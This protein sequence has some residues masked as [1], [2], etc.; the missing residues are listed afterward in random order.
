LPLYTETP[1]SNSYRISKRPFIKLSEIPVIATGAEVAIFT[2]WIGSGF[3]IRDYP[4][5]NLDSDSGYVM[6]ALNRNSRENYSGV[7]DLRNSST[8]RYDF[9]HMQSFHDNEFFHT[10]SWAVPFRHR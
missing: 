7:V 1:K 9:F 5:V 8:R 6:T 10:L 3:S 4:L 2:D